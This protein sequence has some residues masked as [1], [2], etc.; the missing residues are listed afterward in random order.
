MSECLCVE[1]QTVGATTGK[2]A[3]EENTEV[4]GGGRSCKAEAEHRLLVSW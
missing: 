3:R 4:A 1:F 2:K